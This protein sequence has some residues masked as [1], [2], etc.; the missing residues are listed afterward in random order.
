M[1]G[2]GTWACFARTREHG[3]VHLLRVGLRIWG[4]R[5]NS[6]VVRL[7]VRCQFTR[8]LMCV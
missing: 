7:R 8:R 2:L 6:A 1:S 4:G 5:V 3:G